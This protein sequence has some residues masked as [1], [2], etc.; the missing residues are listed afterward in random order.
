MK[1]LYLC[2]DAGIP[3]L[4]RKGASI[5]VRELVAAFTRAGHQVL[6]AAQTLN[7]SPWEKP[8]EIPGTVLQVRPTS[9][10]QAAAQAFKE[11]GDR[12]GVE[13]SLAGEIRR[14]LYNQELEAELIRRFDSDPPDFVYERASLHGTAGVGVARALGVPLVVELNAPLAVEQNAYR[15]NGLGDLGA[16]AER[17]TLSQADA[18]LAVSAPLR[19]HVL[20]LGVDPARVHVCPNGVDP[21][22]FQ[23]G[24]P[25]AGLRERL[26]LGP[27]PVLGFVGGL[28]PWHGVEALPELLE[29][30]CGGHPGVQLVIAGDGQLRGELEQ[31]LRRRGLAARA[32]F[33][34]AIQHDEVGAVL[35]MIDIALAPY[36]RLDH[37]FY[38]SPLKLFEYMASGRAVVAADC[39]QISEL[40]R[41][42]ETGVLYPPGDLDALAAACDGLLRQPKRRLALGEAAARFI[43][44]HYTWDHNARRAVA[45]AAAL[46]AARQVPR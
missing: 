41:S 37:P 31:E 40:I 6:V 2:P 38:F 18:V 5:H 43:R 16:R 29:R 25:D 34:G 39:G 26:G 17:W 21:A 44:N 14:I 32:V 1:I 42:G 30:L 27:G 7:K 13:G 10:T 15:G 24:A 28:R 11:L 23:P 19:E 45:L 8:A 20:S 35:R 9:S 12:L 33:L 3:V 4:G 36:P 22:R 46:Q